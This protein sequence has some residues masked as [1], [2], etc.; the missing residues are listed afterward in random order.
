MKI[1][2]ELVVARYNEDLEWLK[3]I[4]KDIKITVYNKGLENINIPYIK[5]PN[6][7][8]ESHTYLQH[9]ITNYNN[10]A[11]QTI[12]CQGDSIFHS[13]D[14][15]NL[16][17]YRNDFEPVQPLS[18]Y[19]WKEGE[20]PNFI[21][22]PPLFILD[23]TKD[24]HIKGNR[25]HV[26]YLDNNFITRYPYYYHE[27]I[28]NKFISKNKESYKIN[29]ILEFQ[30]D[31]F[32]LKN[33]DLTKLFPTCYAAL[34]SINKNVIRDNSVE[35]YNN[36]KSIL[37]YDVREGIWGGIMDHGQMLEKLWLVIF[38]YKKYNKN[39]ID[40]DVN[41]NKN[42]EYNI[43]VK[44]NSIKFKIY[45]IALYLNIEF[46]INNILHSID[47]NRRF[48]SFKKYINNKTILVKVDDIYL[49]VMHQK[50]LT[51][52]TEIICKI[53]FNNSDIE[54]YINNFLFFKFNLNC[55]N[56]NITKSKILLLVKDNKFFD[57]NK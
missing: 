12:F 51:A 16:L 57:L 26:E 36:I 31:R 1:K 10:L 17:K 3:Q 6:I 13:P 9:I 52:M 14:F 11:D 41:T 53:S 55:K 49:S 22:N 19:Y 23:A 42:I 33:I 50:I 27:G 35:F 25:I 18:A 56:N 46:Y 7:G 40:I 37:L 47:V 24:L 15:L 20:A 45:L 39:Y 32:M 38:N 28:F 54:F 43:I 34:F 48:I 30:V 21:S 44:N 2:C 5:L 8:R 29:N 4:P